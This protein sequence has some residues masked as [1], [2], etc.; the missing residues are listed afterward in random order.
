MGE[1]KVESNCNKDNV[2]GS[3]YIT[4]AV[5]AK[6]RVFIIILVCCNSVLANVV[7][8]LQLLYCFKYKLQLITYT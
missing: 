2:K 6:M 8:F 1:K 7:T 3:L 4:H 5:H